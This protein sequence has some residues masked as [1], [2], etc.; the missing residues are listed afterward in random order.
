MNVFALYPLVLNKPV[1][2]EPC[3]SFIQQIEQQ[4][5]PVKGG[6]QL[7]IFLKKE[8][9]VYLRGS[10]FCCNRQLKKVYAVFPSDWC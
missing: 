1:N 5:Q 9:A 4:K 8:K 3:Y 6:T 7:S 10:N 2:P